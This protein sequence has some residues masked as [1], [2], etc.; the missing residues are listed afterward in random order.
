MCGVSG[1]LWR[2][3]QESAR[4]LIQQM[5]MSLKHRGPDDSGVYL[6][7][8]KRGVILA[9]GHRRLSILDLSDKAHQPMQDPTGRYTL[10]Y[11]GEI[12]NYKELRQELVL[13]GVSFESSGDTELVLKALI[14]WGREAFSKFNG[15]WALAFYDSIE[16]ELILSRDR[17]GQKPLYIL[18]DKENGG[19][20]FSSEIKGILGF[21]HYKKRMNLQRIYRYMALSYRYSEALYDSF[22]E[23][24]NQLQ[25]GSYMAIDAS[26]KKT[27][28]QYWKLSMPSGDD[29]KDSEVIEEFRH[30]LI[31]SVRLRLRSDVPVGVL[32]SGGLD[33]TSIACI[34]R[35][36][37]NH[38]V[39]A[40]SGVMGEEKGKYD[41]REYIEEVRR[42]ADLP[43][44]YI[45]MRPWEMFEAVREMLHGYDEP[46][47]TVS[48]YSLY[49]ILER[50]HQKSFKVLLCGHGGD[51]LMAG[52]MDHFHYRFLDLFQSGEWDEL[53]SQVALWDEHQKERQI[54][55]EIKVRWKY[56]KRLQKDRSI[57]WTRY[58]NYENLFDEGVLQ[59]IRN[60]P[61]F[62]QEPYEEEL[63]RRLRIELLHEVTPVLLKAEDRNSM[64]FSVESRCPFFDYRILDLCYSLPGR[65]KIREGVGKWLL[66]ESMRS[67]LPEKVRT[68]KDKAGLICPADQWFRTVNRSQIQELINSEIQ[69]RMGILSR[70]KL[71]AMFDEHLSEKSNHQM[72]LWNYINLCLWHEKYFGE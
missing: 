63:D 22:F 13:E 16:N 66:R 50:I 64:M 46:I 42:E 4:P 41:E 3:S 47:C 62:L 23:D 15:M 44:D 36:I 14:Y 1:F 61:C 48:W 72:I 34:A 65:F 45:T 27:V 69:E 25:P 52:Y 67:I 58:S 7:T 20:V 2:M 10:S 29:R 6:H 17:L 26:G 38:D 9:L 39:H 49:L 11:N 53:K 31:D 40:F 19:F 8:Q 56:L 37:L 71:Q 12:Y 33:S 21:P 54:P 5:T 24:I 60:I 51:E 32:L 28:T 55:D 35:K 68:R 59:D 43:G 18:E 70:E 30:L 57:E